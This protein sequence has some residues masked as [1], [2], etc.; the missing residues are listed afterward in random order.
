[1]S[2]GWVILYGVL[3][4]VALVVG[5]YLR[6][7]PSRDA[8]TRIVASPCQQDPE[9]RECAR[10]RKQIVGVEPLSVPCTSLRRIVRDKEI[11]AR[12]TVCLDPRQDLEQNGSTNESTGDPDAETPD[13]PASD[14]GAGGDGL[15]SDGGADDPGDSGAEVPP[16][17]PDPPPAGGGGGENPDDPGTGGGGG[18][19]TEPPPA[20]STP[21]LIDTGLTGSCVEVSQGPLLPPV[22]VCP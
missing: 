5:G 10:L 18:T 7:E 19:P 13:Q 1:M 3:V 12:F 16:S 6:Y 20:D 2:R 21:P 9:D 8:V 22:K 15:P 11:L 14:D 4:G 17:D